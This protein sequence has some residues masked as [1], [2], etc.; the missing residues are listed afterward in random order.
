MPQNSSA[1]RHVRIT[2]AEHGQRV[3]N[4]LL[5]T[6]K[7]VPRSHV[8]RLLRTGQVRINGGRVRAQT[9]LQAGDEV[10][11]PPWRGP[12]PSEPAAAPDALR[13][14]IAAALI[15]EDDDYLVLNKPSG[16]AV[17]GGSGVSFG[18]IEVLRQ[19][20]PQSAAWELA[21]RIDRQTSGCLLIA[22]HRQALNVFHGQLREGRVE[23][24][25]LALLAGRW[26]GNAVEVDRALVKN[27]LRGGERRVELAGDDER[28]QA[29]RS[30]FVPQRVWAQASLVRV[31]IAT[32]RTHQIRVHAA[33]LGLPVAG[34]DKYGERAANQRL[35]ALGLRRLFLHAHRLA[36]ERPGSSGR[37]DVQAAL[38]AELQAVIAQ[39][40]GA[41]RGG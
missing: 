22:K 38:P 6:L 35:R 12:A 20:R 23:K 17:H 21:H 5:K 32:G 8:Y 3:D 9:R 29:A 41:D 24:Q 13:E 19:L 33:S 27:R 39:L 18:L 31:A 4:F 25:Y 30:R 36:F 37:L 16:I 1:V 28:G 40:E 10:R 34:D 15:H 11:L 7:G 26:R 14:R 2:A